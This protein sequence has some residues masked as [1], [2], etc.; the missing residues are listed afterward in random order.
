MDIRR[1]T[2]IW[3]PQIGRAAT[4]Y[5]I[6]DRVVLTAWHAIA[7]PGDATQHPLEVRLFDEEGE[8]EWATARRLWP[9]ESP[10]LARDPASDVALL[11]ITD[12]R[13]A[14]PSLPPV[15]WGRVS[16]RDRIPCRA[17]GFP[18]SEAQP[19]Y[20][21]G[22]KDIS[23]HIERYTG[24]GTGLLTIHVDT[25]AVPR[26]RDG[27][28]AWAGGSGA[29]AFCDDLLT[30]VLVE[31]RRA[32]YTGDAL[33]AVSIAALV[34]RCGFIRTLSDMGLSLVLDN[35]DRLETADELAAIL[36]TGSMVPCA[37]VDP[38]QIGVFPS[39]IAHA[40]NAQLPYV[41]RVI[42][43]DLRAL[44]SD[45]D[46]LEA[47]MRLVVV[48]GAPKAGKSRT[49]FEAL[50]S[51]HPTRPL[52]ALRTPLESDPDSP[53]HRPLAVLLQQPADRLCDSTE[54]PIVWI[55]DAQRHFQRGFTSDNLRQLCARIPGVIIAATLH[56][57]AMDAIAELD[58]PLARLLRVASRCSALAPVLTTEE[59]ERARALYR[60]R[61]AP[62]LHLQRLPEFFAA[63]NI[64]QDRYRFHQHDQPIGIAIVRAAV[65]WRRTRLPAVIDQISLLELAKDALAQSFP[66]REITKAAFRAGLAWA[67]HEVAAFASLLR[68]VPYTDPPAYEAFDA[69]AEWIADEEPTVPPHIWSY[70]E[71]RTTPETALWFATAAKAAGQTAIAQRLYG[72][73]I[74]R[75]HDDASTAALFLSSLLEDEGDE[76]GARAARQQA[77]DLTPP[78]EDPNTAFNLAIVLKQSGHTE[79]A[80]IAFQRIIDSH[81]PDM[82]PIAALAAI[83]I[84]ELL[85]ESG[86][87]EGA[88]AA[89]QRAIDLGQ[90]Q[91]AFY[92]G[93]LLAPTGDTQAARTAFQ[94]V[95]D[96]EL[97]GFAPSAAIQL[98]LL[99]AGIGDVQGAQTAYAT[100]IE[101][102]RAVTPDMDGWTD[103]A[104][105]TYEPA[106]AYN[107]GNLLY[108]AGDW[109][110]A[111]EA[112]Q[113]AIDTQEAE[114]APP[115]CLNLGI[116]LSDT[117]NLQEARAAYETAIEL[118]HAEYSPRAALNLGTL[119]ATT[120]DTDA[121]QAA[122]QS[123][124]DS[125]HPDSAPAAASHLA[126]LLRDTG[127]L[128]GARAAFQ[129][130]VDFGHAKYAPIAAL[131]LGDLLSDMHD[132]EGARAA[133][134][135]AVGSG[136]P[137]VVPEAALRLGVLLWDAGEVEGA[138]EAFQRAI[139]FGDEQPAL[140]AAFCLGIL[141]ANARDTD[142]ARAVFQTFVDAEGPDQGPSAAYELGKLLC[143]SEYEE[144]AR[145]AYQLA[146]DSHHEQW[147][148]MAANALGALLTAAGDIDGARA[149]FQY[150]V[151]SQH[152]DCATAAAQNLSQLPAAGGT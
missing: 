76:E 84:G 134:R 123:A 52:L 97:P 147:A 41:P 12:S 15:R 118:A 128:E 132:E 142:G 38:Y 13:W 120:E 94:T 9:T 18:R 27:Q 88:Q 44:L 26:T 70:L 148:P 64:L 63:V 140:E 121:A 146:I 58:E 39:D 7:E 43:Q 152:S 92:L 105:D 50:K 59:T 93:N 11:E 125:G 56:D 4:G 16:G 71:T 36:G 107:L 77:I 145:V 106:A 69:I 32:D 95:I 111:R 113:Q 124:M 127:D 49:L 21:R 28:S 83:N 24:L 99:L 35:T 91:A 73:L 131:H 130:A 81:H 79:E 20:S 57:S 119:L 42:D 75:R 137:S 40:A 6:G 109:E 25:S 65:V 46:A 96:S 133:Y 138:Q 67:T 100:A 139:D 37:S 129:A 5:L 85:G 98:G 112:Y 14:P 108:R 117:G 1:V 74:R 8:S 31:D 29:A 54:P 2:Q 68:K 60:L 150:A 102:A 61:D 89:F 19:D 66:N 135:L 141:L 126:I 144:A 136:Y 114:Y 78:T 103:L 45:E 116:L 53:A 143:E 34:D 86:N 55:D 10:D 48:R 122:F 47:C 115:A 17:V 82:A 87:T 110:G 62:N 149:A 23:G 3:A 33:R 51:T 90:P 72:E 104:R 101:M 22:T 151:N 30:G 80:L